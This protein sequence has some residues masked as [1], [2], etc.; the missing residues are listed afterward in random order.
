MRATCGFWEFEGGGFCGVFSLGFLGSVDKRRNLL[1]QGVPF[2]FP[3]S[4]F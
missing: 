4:H 3:L 1:V 2:S